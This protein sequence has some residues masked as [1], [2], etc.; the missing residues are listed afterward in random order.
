[1]FNGIINTERRVRA[2]H[3]QLCA[4]VLEAR[5]MQSR[6][7]SSEVRYCLTKTTRRQ[8]VLGPFSHQALRQK[9]NSHSVTFRAVE[10]KSTCKLE[11]D[12][13]IGVVKGQSHP[14]LSNILDQIYSSKN[15]QPS[16]YVVVVRNAKG[17]FGLVAFCT[18]AQG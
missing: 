17:R 1:M 8:F 3:F 12:E 5:L 15:L 11:K 6:K 13:L 14:I 10:S 16:N 18:G 7:R 2:R 4:G 9:S